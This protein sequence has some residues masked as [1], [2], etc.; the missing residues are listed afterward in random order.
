MYRNYSETK[1]IWNIGFTLIEL[2]VVIAIIAILA[3]MLLPALKSAREMALGIK[4]KS[5]LR[6][7]GYAHLSYANDYRGY[8]IPWYSDD[9]NICWTANEGFE[10]ILGYKINDV[11]LYYAGWPLDMLCP[12]SPGT[13]NPH[14]SAGAGRGLPWMSYGINLHYSGASVRMDSTSSRPPFSHLLQKIP[15]PSNKM[16]MADGVHQSLIMAYSTYQNWL[17][18]GD[19]LV[20]SPLPYARVAFRHSK[21][22]NLVYFD[23]HVDGLPAGSVENNAKLWFP[24]TSP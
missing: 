1:R 7:I 19:S 9:F 17:L 14:S 6:N 15:S 21:G 13:K 16:L 5:N 10:P 3:A 11:R 18:Y 12:V 2:L 4:C 8:C 23:G 20:A 24:Y 22:A